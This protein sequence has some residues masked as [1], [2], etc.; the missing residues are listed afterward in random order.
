MHRQQR[1]A[2]PLVKFTAISPASEQFNDADSSPAA[3]RLRFQAATNALGS[4]RAT[5]ARQR[6]ARSCVVAAEGAQRAME[7]PQLTPPPPSGG[8]RV[9]GAAPLASP[10]LHDPLSAAGA[11]SAKRGMPAVQMLCVGGVAAQRCL[12]E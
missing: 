6:C 4:A 11:V 7:Q 10:F 5:A 2:N 8:I 1:P 12:L 9:A 3:H